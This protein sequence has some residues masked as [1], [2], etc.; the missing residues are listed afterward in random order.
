ME[1]KLASFKKKRRISCLFE[2]KNN[3]HIFF[4]AYMSSPC[5][6]EVVL[7]E[8]EQAVP[9]PGGGTEEEPAKKKVSQKKLKKQKMM[10]RD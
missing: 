2:T 6:V 3:E 9:R 8:K 7:A 1:L 10:M 5:H 4:L